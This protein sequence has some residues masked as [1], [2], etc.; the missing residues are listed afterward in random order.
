MY[1]YYCQPCFFLDFCYLLIRKVKTRKNAL[2]EYLDY[3]IFV[4]QLKGSKGD[5][6]MQAT[7]RDCN[8][9]PT[10]ELNIWLCGRQTDLNPISLSLIVSEISAFIRTDRQTDSGHG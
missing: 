1:L 9:H 2:V 3:Q 7:K 10:R 5:G 6:D 4:T 8:A